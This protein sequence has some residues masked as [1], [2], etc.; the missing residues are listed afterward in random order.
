MPLHPRDEYSSGGQV[1]IDLLCH[2]VTPEIQADACATFN[3]PR[4]MASRSSDS[5]VKG[6]LL[7]AKRNG[8]LAGGRRGSMGRPPA[9]E[10]AGR[11]VEKAN[12][13]EMTAKEKSMVRSR[14]H[15][16]TPVGHVVLASG[17]K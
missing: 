10:P 17:S 6:N 5:L 9:E 7:Q 2:E 14:Q 16:T 8:S 1:T 4:G 3:T 13:R 11:G 12:K 15:R